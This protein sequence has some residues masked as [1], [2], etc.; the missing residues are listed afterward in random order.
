MFNIV[1]GGTR[2]VHVTRVIDH[3][4]AWNMS[5]QIEES[6]LQATPGASSFYNDFRVKVYRMYM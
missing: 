4:H 5:K 3:L 1:D 2:A 6:A